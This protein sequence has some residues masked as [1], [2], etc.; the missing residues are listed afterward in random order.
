M[1]VYLY[2]HQ[3]YNS[4]IEAY[5][6]LVYKYNFPKMDNE[7]IHKKVYAELKIKNPELLEAN[8]STSEKT[9]GENI[10]Y[11]MISQNPKIYEEELQ[12]F[13]VKPFYNFI[14]SVFYK[15]G[16]SASASTFIISI[17]SYFL[18]VFL[19]FLFLKGQLSNVF[20]AL[21]LTILISLF[22]PLLEASRHASPDVLA[23]LLLI[24]SVYFTL[25][26]KNLLITTIFGMLCIFTRPDYFVFYTFFLLMLYFFRKNFNFEVKILLFSFSYFVISFGLIQFFNQIPWSVLFMNQFTKVQLYPI[27][28]PDVFNFLDYF[29]VI[30]SSIFLEFNASYFPILLII[31]VSVLSS[32][33]SL[34]KKYVQFFSLFL[35]IIY[36][37]VF[38]RFFIFPSLVSRMMLG[39][40]LLIILSLI[41]VLNSKEQLFRNFP[42]KK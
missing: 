18:I 21:A 10:Y 17:V 15:I 6:G 25:I 19:I 23:C 8:N 42:T 12:L 37:T 27:S 20:L 26:K 41:F 22:K 28:H 13:T 32:K 14:N 5:M 33:Y 29:N 4:D 1:S 7:T 38:I 11:K 39:F 31:I 34:N 3:Y 9:I 30:K 16:F 2:K 40:Y 36:A 24:L 35:F